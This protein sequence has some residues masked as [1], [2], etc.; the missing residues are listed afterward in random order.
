MLNPGPPVCTVK[1]TAKGWATSVNYDL[2]IYNDR[3][4]VARGLSLV[5]GL[6]EVWRNREES[7]GHRIDHDARVAA[8]AAKSG[9]ELSSADPGNRLI[10]ASEI[11]SARLRRG[12]IC[13][14]RL[15][16][17]DDEL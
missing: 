7:F 11:E 3:L 1:N 2:L 12:P 5:S 10:M 9:D 17:H 13:S 6:R 16:L 4:I 8:T 15:K 14:L